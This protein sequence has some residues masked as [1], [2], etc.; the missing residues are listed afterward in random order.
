MSENIIVNLEG[1]NIV[2]EGTEKLEKSKICIGIPLGK[3][4]DSQ[5]LRMLLARIREWTNIYDIEITT[6]AVMPLDLSRNN[7]VI[8]A[9]K[10]NCDYLFFIDSD[11]IIR[12][13]QLERLLSHNKNAI[14]GVYYHKISPYSP[15]PRK[16]VAHGLYTPVEMDGEDLIEIDGV[17]MGCFLAKMD[18]FDHVPYPWFEFKYYQKDGKW[19]QLSEDLYFCQKL[20]DIGIKI[21]CDPLVQ[22]AHVGTSID[23]DMSYKYKEFR[24]DYLKE[25]DMTALELSE[26]TG[27]PLDE[28]HYK[29]KIATEL[30]AKEY[31]EFIKHNRDPKDFYKINKNYIFDLTGWHLTDRRIFDI[32]LIKL[33]KEKY[34]F[35][36]KILDFGSGCGQNSIYLARAGYH[37]TM[38]DYE[39][40][41]S[42]FARFRSHKRGLDIKFYDIE[43]L[44]SDKFDIIIAFDIIEHIPDNEFEKTME[45][46]KSL[47]NDRGKILTTISFGTQ[48]GAHPMHYESSPKKLGIIEK[49]S[50]QNII[51]NLGT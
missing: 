37:V 12:Q 17:G 9:K 30:V 6:D 11:I 42:Q 24:V 27:I 40:Y 2:V 4:V 20:Q 18:I 26:F 10:T 8:T 19:Y 51:E 13:G 45:L 25:S 35:A 3:N 39:G 7:I 34:P 32:E 49:L 14:T 36:K 38:T 43:K 50:N 28:V 23:E 44:I 15:L 41:T 48:N 46:L 1:M 21:Y 22:C 33:I 31:K 47:R 29:W 16:K 5:F